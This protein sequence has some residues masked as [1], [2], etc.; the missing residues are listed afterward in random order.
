MKHVRLG[1]CGI[2]LASALAAALPGTAV[3][4]DIKVV[5]IT[6][7]S[8][9]NPYFAATDKGITDRAKQITPDAKFTVVSADY[10]LNKQFT[11]IDNFIA[12][13]AQV[14]MVNA[15][16]PVAIEPALMKAH[17]AGIAIGAFD[18]AAAGA[19]V[20]VMT[21]NAKA[22]EE[23]C[24]YIVDHLPGKKGNVIIVNGPQVSSIVDRVQGCKKVLQSYPGIKI[25]SDNQNALASRDGGFAIGQ[26]LLTRFPQID[27]VFGIND[28]TSI[29]F[30]LAAKQQHRHDFFITSVDGSPDVLPEIKNKDGLIKASA[31]QDP[32]DMAAEAYSYAVDV[33]N[34]KAPPAKVVLLKPTLITIDNV[35]TYK[36]WDPTKRQ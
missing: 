22:G 17:K 31:A 21:D 1:L 5:G 30:A 4:K 16:N 28:P 10:D 2:T 9:G 3:A 36:G 11:N 24:Q 7:G 27:A 13:G 32:Y 34:G 19:D 12:A 29:G 25:L 20:T 14:I 33:A 8:L 6:V 26:N 23:A 18:V 15:V 35:A